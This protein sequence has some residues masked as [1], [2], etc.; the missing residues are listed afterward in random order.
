MRLKWVTLVDH[1]IQMIYDVMSM[2]RTV[3]LANSTK[4]DINYT[5]L[6][7]RDPYI[8]KIPMRYSSTSAIE[9]LSSF[10]RSDS[11]RTASSR[12]LNAVAA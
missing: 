4:V 8:V 1:P 2:S 11:A 10:L 9:R 7:S 5:I 12:R 3:W 6:P